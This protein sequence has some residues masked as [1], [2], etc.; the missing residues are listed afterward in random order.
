MYSNVNKHLNELVEKRKLCIDELA[1]EESEDHELASQSKAIF[2]MQI[3]EARR[4]YVNP[5]SKK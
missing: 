3:D 1:K 4:F 2:E 5:L